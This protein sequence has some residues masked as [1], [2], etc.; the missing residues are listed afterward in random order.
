M[1]SFDS[2]SAPPPPLADTG[3][4]AGVSGAILVVDDHDLLRLGVSALVQAQAATSG[5]RIAVFEAGNIADAL[6][7]YAAHEVAIGL[8]LLDLALPDTHGLSGLAE[9]RLRFPAARVV[10]LSGTANSTLAQGALALG[11]SAFLPK[12]ADLKEMVGFIRA[13]G[14]FE[15]D[16]TPPQP[17]PPAAL[18]KSLSGYAE[19]AHAS[20]WQELTPRQMQ[21]L[22]WVLEGKA[23]KEIAQL[24]NLSEGTVKNHVSTILLLFGMRSRAQLISM[25]R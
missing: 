3:V 8:V 23:N 5:A 22:Q 25:L 7:L 9:F 17:L 11:A 24:A 13:C 2:P 19:F 12:S 16:G 14:L 1:A 20:A 10:V 4:P 21:V 15:A 6:A 18:P